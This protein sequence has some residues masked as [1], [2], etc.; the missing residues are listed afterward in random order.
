M[1]QGYSMLGFVVIVVLYAVI[2]LMA[3]AG[4]IFIARKIFAP[5]AEQIFYAMF[6]IMIA[7][8][9]LAFTAYFGMATAWRLET[10][11]V[12]A[13]VAIGL[14]GARLPFAL[15]AGYSLHGLWDLLHELQAHGVYSAFAPG[16]LTAIPLAYGVFCLAFDFSVAAYFYTRRDEWSAAWKETP[17]GV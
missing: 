4:A 3:A 11:V 5:K 9:Y 15:I 17:T 12:V 8:F 13:F 2:G 1:G 6:L 7:A 10:A 14:L 16:R